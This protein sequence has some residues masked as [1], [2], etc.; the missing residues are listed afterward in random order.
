MDF[1]E[2]V[3]IPI[4]AVFGMFML[5]TFSGAVALTTGMDK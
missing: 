2:L 4:F 1:V 3:G 5:L